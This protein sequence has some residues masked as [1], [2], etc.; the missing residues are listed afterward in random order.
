MRSPIIASAAAN[1]RS[2]PLASPPDTTTRAVG[3][4][5][6]LPP[7]K[8]LI[9]FRDVARQG[10]DFEG[11]VSDLADEGDFGGGA[12][13]AAWR[14]AFELRGHDVAQ[15]DLDATS[16]ETGAAAGR[17]RSTLLGFGAGRAGDAV[18]GLGIDRGCGRLCRWCAETAIDDQAAHQHHN[19]QQ[20]GQAAP[21]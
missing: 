11:V 14:D 21:G 19:E 4:G 1:F 12:G 2:P 10:A 18:G 15:P 3:S 6:S 20:N 8:P 9:P 17:W 5:P 7:N 13:A 16:S